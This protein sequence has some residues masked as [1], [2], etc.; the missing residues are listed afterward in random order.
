MNKRLIGVLLAVL[1]IMSFSG[2]SQYAADKRAGTD[3]ALTSDK[4]PGNPDLQTP[5]TA[6]ELPTAKPRGTAELKTDSGRYSGQADSNF[7]EIKISG[8]PD[9]K[10]AKVFM[11]SDE[12][13][14]SFNGLKLKSGDNI[15]FDYY[16]NENGQNVIT[17]IEKI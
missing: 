5:G 11:L 12:L 1:L 7:I 17:L 9:E 15:R 16:V 4:T 2:C 14:E 8:V 10:S 3:E 13:K 6:V